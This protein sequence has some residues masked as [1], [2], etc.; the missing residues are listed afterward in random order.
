MIYEPI[1]QMTILIYIYAKLVFWKKY[2]FD[3]GFGKGK[4]A[5]IGFR[6]Y[7]DIW[8]SLIII[9]KPSKNLLQNFITY[10]L[11]DNYARIALLVWVWQKFW[12]MQ[13]FLWIW[14]LL[15]STG[16][17]WKRM[18]WKNGRSRP[19]RLCVQIWRYSSWGYNDIWTNL[20]NDHFDLHLCKISL[21]EKNILL[22]LVLV[23]E[24]GPKLGFACMMISDIV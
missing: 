10:Q 17:E 3:F 24:N 12:T 11:H 7:D 6:M 19:S 1:C 4:R 21:L 15:L 14:A 9:V 2:S 16:L 20:T 23:K 22:I 8:Y 18:W 5:K 13:S